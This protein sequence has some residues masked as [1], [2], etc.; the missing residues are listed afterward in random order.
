MSQMSDILK[1]IFI[2]FFRCRTKGKN[3]RVEK[4]KAKQ[5]VITTT[6][7]MWTVKKKKKIMC[8]DTYIYE[9]ITKKM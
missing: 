4:T 8:F 6:T 7:Q 2:L 1:T 9:N 5:K 3:R